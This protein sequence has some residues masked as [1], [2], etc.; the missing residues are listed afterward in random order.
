M[1]SVIVDTGKEFICLEVSS[2]Q[3][4][5][6]ILAALRALCPDQHFR[7]ADS[8]RQ[9]ARNGDVIRAFSD[10]A[11]APTPP[12]F[13]VPLHTLPL[14]VEDDR[15]DLYV[16]SVDMGLIKLTVPRGLS[17]W[18]LERALTT[19]LGRQR[20]LGVR[21]HK[22]SFASALPVYCLPRRGRSTLVV[23][24]IDLVDEIMDPIV[25]AIDDD[26]HAEL[27]CELLRDPWRPH[28][29]FW[30]E[31]ISRGPVCVA[32]WTASVAGPNQGPPV[33]HVTLGLDICRL[34]GD[35][36][37]L[38]LA[39]QVP[40]YDLVAGAARQ[41]IRWDLGQSRTRE[42]AVQTAAS[43]WPM[44]A[45]PLFSGAMP[46][47]RRAAGCSF[48]E[49]F[50][51]EGT[52]FHLECPQMRVR[53][54]IPCVEGRHIWALRIGNWVHA[55]CTTQLGWD[56]VLEVASLSYWDL[57]GTS[58]HG[59]EQVWTWPDDLLSLSGQCGHVM[60]DGSDPFLECLLAD[61]GP[62]RGGRP[63]TA[64]A[65]SLALAG[66]RLWPAFFAL[67]LLRWPLLS[68]VSASFMSVQ[69]AEPDSGA[70]SAAPSIFQS[71][72]VHEEV[73]DNMTPTWADPSRTCTM[74]WC[75][76]LSCQ[77][78][79]FATQPS[80][81]AEYFERHAPYETVRVHLWLPFHGPAMFD[82][83]RGASGQELSVQ[84]QAAGHVPARHS[85]FVAFDSLGTIVEL[86]SVPP[87]GSRW[88]IV[89]DGLSRELLRPVT[90]WVEED[91][92]AVVTLNSHGQV[93]SLAGTPEAASL[94]HLPQGARGATATPLTRL[95]GVLSQGVLT[96]VDS[97]IGVIGAAAALS[98]RWG[99]LTGVLLQS[100]VV[101]AMM[102][103]QMVIPRAQ[104]AWSSGTPLPRQTC[105]WSHTLP[106]PIVVP[107]AD[108]PDPEG[109]VSAVASTGYG[110]RSYGVFAW[111][112]PRQY[113][114]SAHILHYP[115]GLIRPLSFGLC[116]T[117]VRGS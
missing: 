102:Q 74:A 117:V 7:L 114:D 67:G 99:L 49:R 115:V 72:E 109:M 98:A 46:V 11:V 100:G 78:T 55:A 113:G 45:S 37:Q 29:A 56:E 79:H 63:V 101:S 89:R 38:P 70:S 50:G 31:V 88:W 94:Y 25:H 71:S 97:G 14:F 24:L 17:T 84:L 13:Q 3:P 36:W 87:G 34:L 64:P 106:V 21:L 61:A 44:Q 103:E 90:A 28:S 66:R 112:N 104:A 58:I 82:F 92:R 40:H 48:H 73:Q 19:W 39:S 20:C 27:D 51:S 65:D 43:H 68:V 41:G 53:C 76:E 12:Q 69:L 111:T 16:T 107:Y 110:I 96:I 116:I 80:A 6:A 86:V 52:L 22:L 105:V 81:L 83:V 91:R 32:C 77:N 95:Y 26:L 8:S 10:R 30:D 85:L 60:H 108:P 5:P 1:V 4:G 62:S 54:T 42:V 18:A 23:A 75:H 47:P 57:P 2:R 35:G 15:Q 9:P 93:A 59:S 33:R